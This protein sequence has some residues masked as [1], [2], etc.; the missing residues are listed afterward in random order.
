MASSC[1]REGFLLPARDFPI[2]A[3]RLVSAGA[4][5]CFWMRESFFLRARRLLSAD[6]RLPYAGGEASFRK[7]S[8]FFFLTNGFLPQS[9]KGFCRGEAY[10]TYFPIS[11]AGSILPCGA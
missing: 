11:R 6:E 7:R 5:G 2:D 1:E 10:C 9:E 8:G 3:G 4:S